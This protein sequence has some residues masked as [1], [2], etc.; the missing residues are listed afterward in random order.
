L[1]NV[2]VYGLMTITCNPD[3]PFGMTLDEYIAGAEY[4]DINP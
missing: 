4:G 2:F 1:L 3:G